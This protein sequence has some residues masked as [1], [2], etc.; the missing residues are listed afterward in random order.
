MTL[1]DVCHKEQKS[2]KLAVLYIS[3]GAVAGVQ[4]HVQ[5]LLS[6]KDKRKWRALKTVKSLFE[7]III[8]ILRFGSIFLCYSNVGKAFALL[9]VAMVVRLIVT[10]LVVSGNKL[11]IKDKIFVA[12]AWSPKATVQVRPPAYAT[13]G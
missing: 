4:S 7:L 1:R 13:I 5:S 9:T 6:N 10:F 3:R 8:I 2:Q 12:I 11:S